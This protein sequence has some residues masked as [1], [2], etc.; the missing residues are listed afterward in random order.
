MVAD[1]D[2]D[3]LMTYRL[4]MHAGAAPMAAGYSIITGK[5]MQEPKE[6]GNANG[7]DAAAP[8]AAKW[9]EF[10]GGAK[11]NFDL[12]C[13]FGPVNIVFVEESP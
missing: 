7:D 9:Q 4:P 13:S 6:A 3:T 8:A 1:R 12:D 5:V 10:T 11:G 2:G